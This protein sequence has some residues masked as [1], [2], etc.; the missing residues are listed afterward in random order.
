MGDG[1]DSRIDVSFKAVAA[2]RLTFTLPSLV[3]RAPTVSEIEEVG[4]ECGSSLLTQ[5][6]NIL[7]ILDGGHRF[8]Y[9]VAAA[10]FMACDR[11]P[12]TGQSALLFDVEGGDPP[13]TVIYRLKT[14]APGPCP[15]RHSE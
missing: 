2:V 8:G 6:Q 3:I 15:S 5:S 10:A 1:Y 12:A 4:G 7:Y 9:I 11:L 13:D 14:A